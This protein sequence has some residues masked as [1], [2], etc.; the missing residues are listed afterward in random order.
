M[1]AP[2]PRTADGHPDFSGV[3]DRGNPG[4]AF[5][6]LPSVVKDGL[7]YQ[8]WAAD[9]AKQRAASHSVDHPDAHCLP[10]HPVQLHTHPQPRK[11]VQTPE[12]VTLIYE[13]NGGLRQFFLDGRKLPKAED[14]QPWWFGEPALKAT[15]FELI[16][17]PDIIEYLVP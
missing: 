6:Q 10:L 8:P 16:N 14:V 12:S 13:S 1:D 17:L 4:G 11:I 5:L 9:L 7:P 2:A 3:W 15:G